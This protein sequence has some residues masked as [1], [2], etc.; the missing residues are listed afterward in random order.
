[1]L[2]R[3]SFLIGLAGMLP[4][5]GCHRSPSAPAAATPAPVQAYTQFSPGDTLHLV[6]VQ[7]ELDDKEVR[8]RSGM[9]PDKMSMIYFLENGNLHIDVTKVGDTWV[10]MTV[11][12]LEPA[13]DSVEARVAAW[14]KGSD[15][16]EI[17]V[18]RDK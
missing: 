13:A 12:I 6:Q 7:L 16:Q 4:L 2:K 10:L 17:R 15:S 18:K 3:L 1:M 14:D 11:P 9:P 8:F 5:A